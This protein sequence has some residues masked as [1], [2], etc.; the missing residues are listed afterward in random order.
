MD[1]IKINYLAKELS[2]IHSHS[3][4]PFY[5]NE[6]SDFWDSLKEK[7]ENGDV[8][9]EFFRQIARNILLVISV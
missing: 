4:S 6:E 5:G 1:E 8:D 3:M 7:S 2:E 9:K